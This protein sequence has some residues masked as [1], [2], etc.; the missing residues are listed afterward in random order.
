VTRLRV[1][2]ARLIGTFRQRDM[3]LEQDIQTHMDLLTEHFIEQGMA[4]PQ[5][6]LAALRTLGGVQRT[7]ER[8]RAQRGLPLL[9]AVGQDLKY[10]LRRL[11][12]TPV[13]RSCPGIQAAPPTSRLTGNWRSLPDGRSQVRST[14]TWVRC[15]SSGG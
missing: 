10:G 9:D 12:K 13:F 3:Q 15:L 8:Y 11:I 7:K 14:G 6:R 4:A 5:A 1:F 2:L